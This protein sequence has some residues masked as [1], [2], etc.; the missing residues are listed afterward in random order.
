[1]SR[2]TF[3]TTCSTAHPIND[4]FSSFRNT[5]RL[6]SFFFSFFRHIFD[7]VFSFRLGVFLLIVFTVTAEYQLLGDIHLCSI[8]EIPGHRILNRILITRSFFLA[9]SAISRSHLFRH[10]EHLRIFLLVLRHLIII[11]KLH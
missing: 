6:S 4:C 8:I 10:V 2:S 11:V 3:V 1:M 5:R 9:R 7:H